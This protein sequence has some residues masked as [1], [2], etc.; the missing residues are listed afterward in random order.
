MS[1]AAKPIP[2]GFHTLTPHLTVRNANQAIAFYKKAFGAKNDRVSYGPDG[3]HV[4]HAE[5]EIGDSKIMFNDE[6]PDWQCHSPLSKPGAGFLIHIY[7]DDVDAVFDRAVK[8]GATPT[9][10]VGDQFWGD[11]YGQ[12]TDPFGHRWSIGTHK[13][14]LSREEINRRAEAFFSGGAG[15]SA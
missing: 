5:L 3:K 7:V 10:P 6:M 12:L 14:D 9:M 8:A 13:E 15:K 4:M 11:R 2:D 1:L